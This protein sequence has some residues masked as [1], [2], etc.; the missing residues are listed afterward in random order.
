[1]ANNAT[2]L[3][4]GLKTKSEKN[5]VKSSEWGRCDAN[6]CKLLSSHKAG[7]NSLC[8]YHAGHEVNHWPAI[9]QSIIDNKPLI[10]KLA[11][12][13]HASSSYWADPMRL[14]AMR[15]WDVLP[16]EDGEPASIYLLRFTQWVHKEIKDKASELMGLSRRIT[17]VRRNGKR[18]RKTNC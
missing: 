16:M 17:G 6:G 11:S 8:I 14:A 1:M 13:T 2:E 12:M 7:G 18:P 3:V 10:N 9:T 5:Y 15:G 4:R